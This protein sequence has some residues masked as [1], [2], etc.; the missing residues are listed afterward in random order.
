MWQPSSASQVDIR[1]SVGRAS[2][3]EADGRNEKTFAPSNSRSSHTRTHAPRCHRRVSS[4][5]EKF[6][7]RVSVGESGLSA[8]DCCCCCCCRALIIGRHAPR[9]VTRG[10]VGP[11]SLAARPISP[12]RGSA[13]ECPSRAASVPDAM[14]VR[15]TPINSNC[16]LMI[17]SSR[18]SS[19]RAVTCRQMTHNNE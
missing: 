2:M 3:F 12:T 11:L 14:H 17:R 5:R 6:K 9:A 18:G 13:R 19:L 7:V 15:H 8:V 16:F 4:N 10:V 1:P